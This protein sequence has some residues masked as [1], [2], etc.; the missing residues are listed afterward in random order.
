LL[1]GGFFHEAKRQFDDVTSLPASTEDPELA[2]RFNGDP[3][4]AAHILRALARRTLMQRLAMR[5]KPRRKPSA[6][7]TP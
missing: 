1:Y 4:A 3:R 5:R 2:R 7:M 6:P